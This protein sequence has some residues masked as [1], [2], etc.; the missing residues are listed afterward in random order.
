MLTHSHVTAVIGS[1]ISALWYGNQGH[2]TREKQCRPLPGPLG[3]VTPGTPFAFS[4]GTEH[5]EGFVLL[6]ES[7]LPAQRARE[8]PASFIFR[9]GMERRH[10]R[11][12]WGPMRGAN[13][14]P[15]LQG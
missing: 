1:H 3:L 5:S 14:I 6:K 7:D 4:S 10:T 2:P 15:G 13:S 9:E 11:Q 8:G 12:A